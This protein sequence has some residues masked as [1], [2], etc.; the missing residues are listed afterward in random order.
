MDNESLRNKLMALQSGDKIAFEDIYNHLKTPMYTIILRIT[1]DRSLSEDILQEV[2]FKLYKSPPKPPIRK[3]RAYLFQMARNLA[4]DHVRKF[5][6]YVNWDSVEN[7]V[8]LPLDDFSSKMDID[9]ALKTLPLQECQIVSLRI[10]GGL[11]FREISEVMNIPLG[12]VLWRY[13]KAIKQLQSIL[14]GGVT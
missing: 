3:P 7:I 9:H 14:S 1:H 4:I 11:K 8:Y 13:R 2:F 6:K 10:N 12:T 5:P